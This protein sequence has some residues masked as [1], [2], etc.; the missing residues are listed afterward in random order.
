[1]PATML[2][3]PIADVAAGGN[4]NGGTRDCPDAHGI[5]HFDRADLFDHARADLG[6][7]AH[8]IFAVY[9]GRVRC[10]ATGRNQRDRNQGCAN[11]LSGQ[12]DV[13]L[14]PL[15]AAVFHDTMVVHWPCGCSELFHKGLPCG[16]ACHAAMF[17]L[18]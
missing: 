10:R 15:I 18:E 1:M 13:L 5:F 12:H 4:A 14:A 2:P 3:L 9:I 8:F 17:R 16:N 11:K 7:A 6:G